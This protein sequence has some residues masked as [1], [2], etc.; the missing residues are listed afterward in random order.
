SVSR[1]FGDCEAKAERYGGNPN[2]VIPTPDI[3]S[4]KI[5]PNEHDFIVLGCDGIFDKLSNRDAI[6][7]VWNSVKD[8]KKNKT[9]SQVSNIHKQ[10]GLGVDYILKNSL[11][12]RTLDNVTVVL[13]AFSNFKRAAFESKKP[14][15]E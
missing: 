14:V 6:Q 9:G 13:I 4:F 8:N 12:R 2:V 3:K 1:T 11:L 5:M 10:S 7:C 15:E